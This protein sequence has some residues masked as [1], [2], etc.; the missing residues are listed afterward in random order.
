MTTATP[1]TP[2]AEI[3][4]AANQRLE[5]A[6]LGHIALAA[7]LYG[8]YCGVTGGRSA[9]TGAELP[10]FEKCPVLVRAGWLAVARRS[11]PRSLP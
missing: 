2:P 9:V 7:V 10:P 8:T 1:Y 4:F 6:T 5:T 3:I 11:T